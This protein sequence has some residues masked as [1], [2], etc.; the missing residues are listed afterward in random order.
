MSNPL[1]IDLGPFDFLDLGCGS[2]RS[3]TQAAARF[4]A[5]RG[6]GIDLSQA[7][8]EAAQEAGVDVICANAAML[9]VDDQVRFTTMVDFL[10]HLPDLASVEAVIA[11]AAR[12]STDFLFISHPSF[13]G[14][15]Y[16]RELGLQQYWW[17][18]R[19]H[20]AHITVSDYCRMLDRLAL[21]QYMIRYVEPIHDSQDPSVLSA[22]EPADQHP[23]DAAIHT[24]KRPVMFR[25]P[26]WRAQEIFVALRAFEPAEWSAITAD[27]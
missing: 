18:W 19:G 5:S 17:G 12:A 24:S 8:V 20:P 6:L 2:G 9:A 10:E 11:S 1:G 7:K 26:I 25:R 21:R 4:G 14:E 22:D 16:L 15:D 23:Y 13:E 3:L 27:R